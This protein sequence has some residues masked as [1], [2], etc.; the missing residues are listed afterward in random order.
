MYLNI[1]NPEDGICLSNKSILTHVLTTVFKNTPVP[2]FYLY[3]VDKFL[4]IIIDLFNN[5]SFRML[6]EYLCLDKPTFGKSPALS[7]VVYHN[8]TALTDYVLGKISIDD[9][10]VAPFKLASEIGNMDIIRLFC[11]KDHKRFY[12]K[13]NGKS[14]VRTRKQQ[15]EFLEVEEI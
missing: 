15:E 8:H 2:V 13:A 1:V 10:A 4:A 11:I 9:I 12:I 5:S 7:F 14:A 3:H 6:D